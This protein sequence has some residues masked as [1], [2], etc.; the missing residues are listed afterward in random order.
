VTFLA[1]PRGD[2]R[3][4]LGGAALVCAAYPP[5]HLIVPS[6]I[7]LIPAVWLIV[8]GGDDE[9]PLRRHFAQGVWFGILSHGL[10]LYWMVGALWRYT[11]LSALAYA[12]TII[13]LGL[14]MGVVFALSGWVTRRTQVSLA[15]TFPV[16]WTAAEWLLGHLWDL[17]F[18]WLGLGT[19]LTG[20][21]TLVQ[22]ADIIGARGITFLLVLANA[23]LAVAWLHRG[24]RWR[25]VAV[26]GA[27]LGAVL[28]AVTYGVIR[29]RSLTVRSPG[30]VA[31]L[32]PNIGWQE[33]WEPSER[34][35]IL[36][37]TLN[38]AVTA[39]HEGEPD[40]VVWPEAA[41][42]GYFETRP[43][44]LR[45]ISTLSLATGVPHVVGALDVEWT[46]AEERPYEYYN[47]AFL[48]DSS[49]PRGVHPVYRKRYLV[50]ITE[51]VPFLEPR[52]FDLEF[53]GGFS[54]GTAQRV[55]ETS[56]GRFG[57]LICFESAFENLTRAYRASGADF[58]VNMTN[59]S[60]FGRT[61]APYQHAAHLVMRAIET[62]M[63]IARA[64]NSGI[65]GFVD[66]FGRWHHQTSLFRE[67]FT[68][69]E[70]VT[71]SS[72]P[73]Y[74]RLGDWIGSLS[75]A[76]TVILVSFAARR[77]P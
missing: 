38:L 29:E 9:A 42:P 75:L 64:A 65:S 61:S 51:R 69:G 41:V 70:L 71:S 37:R 62:R 52:W 53:F 59:D 36:Y 24:S 55:F 46:E 43:D 19:S 14:Y 21:P 3:L 58:V 16:H 1:L 10:V 50:P 68:T 66:P 27:V 7:C 73:P 57:V 26:G 63:G 2:W 22:V 77:R 35:S 33:K 28:I 32:Q 60:W 40:L 56:V 45:D 6:F 15:V 47:A 30:T 17:R 8:A 12:A 13:T 67:T 76:M 4:V 23:A 34:D 44:W 11:P 72:V 25:V 18:P 49:A 48:I 5:F 74:V 39:L 31:L 54:A 20:F